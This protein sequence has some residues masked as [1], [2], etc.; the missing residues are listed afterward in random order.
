MLFVACGKR[1][2][3]THCKVGKTE[4]YIIA[5]QN[6]KI[7]QS[8]LNMLPVLI[9]SKWA[10]R[11]S[12]NCQALTNEKANNLTEGHARSLMDHGSMENADLTKLFF[13]FPL[14]LHFA[15]FKAKL[16]S[17]L[18]AW[19]FLV[20]RQTPYSLLNAPDEEQ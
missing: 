18:E 6:I 13:F 7:L 3:K 10:K 15:T 17:D 8:L 9:L 20:H 11:L 5:T 14:I 16:Y 2:G 19:T 1:N 4:N 12:D